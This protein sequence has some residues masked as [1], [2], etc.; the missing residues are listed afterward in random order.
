MAPT[1]ISQMV[2]EIAK[3]I[4]GL[5]LAY[6]LIHT[7][8]LMA[9]VGALAAIPGAELCSLIYLMIR[10]GKGKRALMHEIRTSPQVHRYQEKKTIHKDLLHLMLPI[11]I[12]AAAMS[13]VSLVDNFMVINLLKSSGFSQTM[14]E[15]RFGLMTGYVSPIVYVPV[16]ISTALQMSLVPSISASLKLMRFKEC[17]VNTGI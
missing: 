2:E 1:A 8:E 7:S 16:S 6:W 3:T 17:T 11:T 15:S 9:A 5:V 14:A 13:L 10:Y 12:A 4:F